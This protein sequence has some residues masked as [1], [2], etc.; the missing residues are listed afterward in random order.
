MP[1]STP[2]TSSTNDPSGTRHVVGTPQLVGAVLS[3][4]AVIAFSALF[5]WVRRRRRRESAR[6]ARPL[7]SSSF[8]LLPEVHII[9]PYR[10]AHPPPSNIEGTTWSIAVAS[11]FGDAA[12]VAQPHVPMSEH[13]DPR[14]VE[15]SSVR[16]QYLQH[17]LRARQEEIV[18][19][20]G[21]ERGLS[22]AQR[23]SSTTNRNLGRAVAQLEN[24]RQGNEALVAR[25]QEL[26]AQL[27]SAWALRLSDDPPPGYTTLL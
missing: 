3:V 22:T 19:I 14:S 20:D 16:R 17:G 18:D 9:T 25:I 8:P 12:A 21:L 24:A 13:S 11:P 7:A 15:T 10:N 1:P 26:E 27:Q 4:G 6:R 23:W 2:S 5:L